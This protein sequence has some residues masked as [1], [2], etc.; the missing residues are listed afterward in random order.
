MNSKADAQ[1]VLDSVH[2]GS[3]QVLGTTKQGH[4]V[5][6]NAGVTGF[7]NNPGAG[8]VNQPTNVFLI[9]GTAKPSVV[10]TNPNWSSP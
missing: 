4:L 3:A 7:N 6:R 10:P 2:S 9:K 1:S 5:V 8:F